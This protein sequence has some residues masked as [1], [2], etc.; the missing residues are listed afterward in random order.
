MARIK[1]GDTVIVAK[2]RDRGKIGPVIRVIKS[3][4]KALVDTVNIYKKQIKPSKKYPQGGI[5]DVSQPVPLSNLRVICPGCKKMTKIKFKNTG[6]DKRRICT[7]CNEVLD[8]TDVKT[9]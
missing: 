3:S 4:E 8:A 5:I 6:K 1:K 9:K 2:G 7:I